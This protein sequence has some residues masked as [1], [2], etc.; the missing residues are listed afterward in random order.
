M[1]DAM[2]EKCAHQLYSQEKKVPKQEDMFDGYVPSKKVV[3][4]RNAIKRRA[5]KDKQTKA[6]VVVAT[7][8][9]P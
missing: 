5:R 7:P 2:V 6:H 1:G 4:K 8:E 3:K 9:N